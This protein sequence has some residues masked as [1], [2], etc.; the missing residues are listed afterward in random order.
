MENRILIKT[1]DNQE[2]R[3]P[4]WKI[5]KS[6]LL[7][8]KQ[9]LQTF[10]EKYSGA[11]PSPITRKTICPE[12]L[13]LFSNALDAHDLPTYFKRLPAKKRILL[14][15]ATGPQE[16]DSSYITYELLNAYYEQVF[17]EKHINS[18][19]STKE[20]AD[21]VQGLII[22]DN[23]EHQNFIQTKIENYEKH[24][25]SHNDGSYN[26][27]PSLLSIQPNFSG[28]TPQLIQSISHESNEQWLFEKLTNVVQKK[29]YILTP[30]E[31]IDSN[32]PFG[33]LYV[34]KNKK[35]YG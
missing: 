32:D 31:P 11:L 13:Y 2:C 8:T 23:C 17:I 30:M 27:L 35:N 24:L 29:Q 18:R 22:R 21:Y 9:E 19:L 34:S 4:Q 7:H 3:L 1:W 12:K 6:R 10:K 20:V 26:D 25:V 33:Q 5:E 15:C 28:Y 14:L 16:L